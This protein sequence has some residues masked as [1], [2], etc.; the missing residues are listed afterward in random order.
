MFRDL[1]KTRLVIILV[2]LTDLSLDI[3]K[4]IMTYLVS[5]HSTDV[6]FTAM[7]LYKADM[8]LAS[9]IVQQYDSNT[10]MH[11]HSIKSLVF[12]KKPLA[13]TFAEAPL[14]RS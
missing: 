4:W 7:P 13:H 10:A 12:M 1:Y 2:S 8:S 9:G 5:T 6:I 14:Q 11:L 3:S